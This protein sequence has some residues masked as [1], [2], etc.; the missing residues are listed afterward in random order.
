[1]LAAKKYDNAIKYFGGAIK[2]DPKNAAAYKGMGYA[3][4]YKGD[5]AKALPYLNYA[6][7]LNPS[8]TALRK[9]VA[10]LGGGSAPAAT[11][12]AADQA[13]QNGLKYM[14]AK[15]YQYAA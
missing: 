6:S 9:Y 13:Y 15:Q 4:I 8:D 5:K 1:M 7:K 2:A 11:G 10:S 12:S 14:N 3:Y